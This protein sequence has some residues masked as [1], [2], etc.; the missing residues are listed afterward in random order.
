M[1]DY[2]KMIEKANSSTDDEL[3]QMIE[4]STEF[5]N[6]LNIDFVEETTTQQ[7]I[8]NLF[9][10]DEK[11]AIKLYEMVAKVL[12]S[13]DNIYDSVEIYEK[14]MRDGIAKFTPAEA[15][16]FGAILSLQMR[17]QIRMKKQLVVK[18]PNASNVNAGMSE[19]KSQASAINTDATKKAAKPES[20]K[21]LKSENHNKRCFRGN[22]AKLAVDIDDAIGEDGEI[23]EEFVAPYVCDYKKQIIGY[24]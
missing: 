21:T 3:K 18:A 16:L 8:A 23:A 2:R 9:G 15:T 11:E 13:T 10:V 14:A 4:K 20:D 7:F 1:P 19:N 12:D 22:C 6:K 17:S 24:W 5:Y